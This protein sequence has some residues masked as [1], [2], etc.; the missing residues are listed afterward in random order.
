[1]AEI[2]NG[3][4]LA[5]SEPILGAD[6]AGHDACS[7]REQ[8]LELTAP[9]LALSTLG[10]AACGGGGASPGP[11]APATPSALSATPGNGQVVLTWSS[12]AG[13]TE[14]AI[15]RGTSSGGPFTSVGDGK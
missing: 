4:R 7:A 6:A 8:R 13:A 1:M 11:A 10:L 12:S 3:S 15:S 5:T 2:M 14:Y 9:I